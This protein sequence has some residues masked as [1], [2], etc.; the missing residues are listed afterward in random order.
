MSTLIHSPV[1]HGGLP[2]EAE[3]SN[4]TSDHRTHKAQTIHYLPIYRNACG[5]LLSSVN[6]LVWRLTLDSQAC[7][8]RVPQIW[9]LKTAEMDCVTAPEARDSRSR[10]RQGRSLLEAQRED[11]P[12][13]RPAPGGPRILA[14]L[15]LGCI[16]SVPAFVFTEHSPECLSVSSRGCVIKTTP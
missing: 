4:C 15:G 14:C 8:N 16:T 2:T 10:C 9:W 1:A 12:R 13:R 11:Q 6:C 7:G 5:T 3:L